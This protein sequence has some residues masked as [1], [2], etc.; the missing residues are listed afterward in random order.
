MFITIFLTCQSLIV[1]ADFLPRSTLPNPTLS[2]PIPSSLD[3]PYPVLSYPIVLDLPY[4]TLSYPGLYIY[5]NEKAIILFRII[6]RKNFPKIVLFHIFISHLIYF[7]FC[8]SISP[9]SFSSNRFWN[10]SLFLFIYYHRD[11]C[12]LILQKN[13]KLLFCTV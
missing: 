12:A 6:W 13:I 1:E 5:S 7:L 11:I 10:N 4:L 2:N 9:F 8:F 3:L